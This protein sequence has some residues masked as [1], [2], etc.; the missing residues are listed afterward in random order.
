MLRGSNTFFSI[1]KYYGIME[2]RL[3]Y[4]SRFFIHNWDS[5]R[6][7]STRIKSTVTANPQIWLSPASTVCFP[8]FSPRAKTTSNEFCTLTIFN[9]LNNRRFSVPNSLLQGSTCALKQDNT[10]TPRPLFLMRALPLLGWALSG[11]RGLGIFR[12]GWTPI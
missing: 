5:E 10:A 3:L 11:E 6:G 1:V 7:K 12:S 4:S 9:E 8:T 2:S